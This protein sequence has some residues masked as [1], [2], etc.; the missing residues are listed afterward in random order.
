MLNATVLKRHAVTAKDCCYWGHGGACCDFSVE[1]G[2]PIAVPVSLTCL[3]K[4]TKQISRASDK[5]ANL[6]RLDRFPELCWR[7]DQLRDCAAIK[8]PSPAESTDTHSDSY[9]SA[10][11]GRRSQP[12]NKYKITFNFDRFLHFA[13][14]F[15]CH[16]MV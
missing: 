10:F 11:L 13:S 3:R 7:T 15:F 12:R 4:R 1:V 14:S 8:P 5:A 9:S 2:P 6:R 16:S